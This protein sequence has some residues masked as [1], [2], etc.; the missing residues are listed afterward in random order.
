MRLTITD[1]CRTVQGG[2]WRL[3]CAEA[4]RLTQGVTVDSHSDAA[5][6]RW[7][8]WIGSP[9]SLHIES[10]RKY[11]LSRADRCNK[12]RQ[13]F[14]SP[15]KVKGD[16]IMTIH[17]GSTSQTSHQVPENKRTSLG[18][19][20]TA[21]EAYRMWKSEPDKVHILDVRTPEEYVFV[22]HAE[23]ARNIPLLFVKHE[24]NAEIKEFVVEPNPD[25]IAE[26][27]R[28]FK[29]TDAL[30]VMCGP[31]AV[32]PE[33]STHLQSRVCERLQYHRWHGRGQGRRSQEQTP[34]KAV[35]ERLEELRI[36][37]DL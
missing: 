25:F 28:Q 14:I 6:D 1:S 18:H 26:A 8:H 16:T 7:C 34:R 11:R 5:D 21:E 10:V 17:T 35:E 33:R 13:W 20:V 23:M 36:A 9:I 12:R 30:L 29:P 19:Y 27:K 15:P 24:W 31:G 37:L 32:V 22:G 2:S 4:V 3:P